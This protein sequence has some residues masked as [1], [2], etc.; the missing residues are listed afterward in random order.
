M[1]IRTN[2]SGDLNPLLS[3]SVVSSSL[4]PH[5]LQPTRLLCPWGF[6]RQEYWSRLPC[7]PPGD[8]PNPGIKSWSPTHC[9][10]ILYWLSHRKALVHH[11]S[12]LCFQKT[13]KYLL[14]DMGFGNTYSID[15]H[16]AFKM[17]RCSG[18]K[19]SISSYTLKFLGNWICAW[20]ISVHYMRPSREFCTRMTLQ[21]EKAMAPHS[22]TP[23]WKIAWMEE[24]GRLQA[25][26]C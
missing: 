6:S 19:R 12:L 20:I 21:M 16:F 18:E 23:A 10:Q 9:R 15:K 17:K 8:L 7:P 4:W 13:L 3:L 24:P 2:R 1:F 26:D 11:C 5:G 14:L 22:S 25:W